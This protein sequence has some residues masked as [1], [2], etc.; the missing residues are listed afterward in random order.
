MWKLPACK[1]VLRISVTQLP[2][3]S[4]N[5]R[6]RLCMFSMFLE[7]I[8]DRFGQTVVC[9]WRNR[10]NRFHKR[11]LLWVSAWEPC[12]VGL[13]GQE[14]TTYE[15]HCN[16]VSPFPCREISFLV[17]PVGQSSWQS[18]RH[19]DPRAPS[20]ETPWLSSQRCLWMFGRDSEG[21]VLGKK[22]KKEKERLP[23]NV[24]QFGMCF[25]S[26]IHSFFFF[27]VRGNLGKEH[28]ICKAP[29]SQK[30]VVNVLV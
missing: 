9:V 21:P 7:I 4:V 23:G 22:T 6:K 19:A 5:V 26:F 3:T 28:I 30:C 24:C 2:E 10:S 25:H 11:C 20:G 13:H 1:P 16:T 17:V 27:L 12:C 15:G 14:E 8:L 18:S 29:A